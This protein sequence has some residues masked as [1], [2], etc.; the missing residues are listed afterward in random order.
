[1]SS[2]AASKRRRLDDDSTS[3]AGVSFVAQDV[4]EE[5]EMM[6]TDPTVAGDADE[7]PEQLHATFKAAFGRR[8]EAAAV[9]KKTHAE[10]LDAAEELRLKLT[11]E[12]EELDKKHA[13]ARRE[14]ELKHSAA[15][16]EH[17]STWQ[18]KLFSARGTIEV[19][20]KEVMLAREELHKN[21]EVEFDSLLSV[22]NDGI[23]AVMRF[24]F[25]LEIGR[26]QFICRT[27]RD[28]L[29]QNSS[30]WESADRSMRNR[31]SAV[32]DARAN[33]VRYHVA[34]KFAE[35]LEPH[36]GKHLNG[37]CSE[38]C[39]GCSAFP[40]KLLIDPSPAE[41]ELFVRFSRE[42]TNGR[43][44]LL[45]GFVDYRL[46]N[47]PQPFS[48]TF[49]SKLTFNLDTLDLS[50]WPSMENLFHLNGGDNSTRWMDFVRD[51]L[52]DL[53]ATVVALERSTSKAHLVV[54]SADFDW[55]NEDDNG[56]ITFYGEDDMGVIPHK[57]HNAD[58]LYC[59]AF[60]WDDERNADR[61]FECH[62]IQSE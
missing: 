14:L 55:K 36:V 7:D 3:L 10:E 43:I 39:K 37:I 38:R 47:T 52:D 28:L 20:D 50:S 15:R 6:E 42:T 44:L 27:F 31:S 9:L 12:M 23:M 25:T 34:S 4:P 51:A 61:K 29:S 32:E 53:T 60:K 45:E 17:R 41:Y 11:T 40:S 8:K 33:V 30:L 59:L 57:F 24:L 2:P 22:G 19:A 18:P 16:K 5:K 13:A 1:M 26:S 62:V 48:K 54:G 46:Y 35:R 58:N 21:G 56:K 49:P